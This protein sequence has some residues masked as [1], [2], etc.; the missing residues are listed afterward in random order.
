MPSRQ[1]MDASVA[2]G[3]TREGTSLASKQSLR[4]TQ[5][6]KIQLT[7]SA[8]TMGRKYLLLTQSQHSIDH[9]GRGPPT[10]V[11]PLRHECCAS[12][13]ENFNPRGGGLYSTL[14][15]FRLWLRGRSFLT[16]PRSARSRPDGRN[17]LRRSRSFPS[18][19]MCQGVLC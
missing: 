4:T 2:R 1:T 18:R 3:T 8:T 6:G 9:M 15:R 11:R 7:S 17:H 14:T 19:D 10:F 5:R 12:E 13:G 16:T